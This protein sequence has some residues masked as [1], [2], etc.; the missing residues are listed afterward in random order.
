VAVSGSA[1]AR[2]DISFRANRPA[3]HDATLARAS[4]LRLTVGAAAPTD[5]RITFLA[6]PGRPGLSDSRLVPEK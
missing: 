6:D 4:D 2:A 1:L 5:F 3:V